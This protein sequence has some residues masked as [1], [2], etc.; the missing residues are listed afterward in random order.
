MPIQQPMSVHIWATRSSWMTRIQMYPCPKRK[1][2]H[3]HTHTHSSRGM[4]A[5]HCACHAL[6]VSVFLQGVFGAQA[7]SFEKTR[8]RLSFLVGPLLGDEEEEAV[9][10]FLNR[11]ASKPLSR[12]NKA[13]RCSYPPN[14]LGPRIPE[15]T[16]RAASHSE[17]SFSH[18][19][20]SA[21]FTAASVW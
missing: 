21:A 5:S 8:G 18:Q 17:S 15:L 14:P 13:K 12:C 7:M 3:T 6:C 11:T 20:Q 19:E 1:V 10:P 2:C 4:D 16:D 9:N